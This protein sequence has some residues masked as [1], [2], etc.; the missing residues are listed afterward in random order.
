MILLSSGQKSREEIVESLEMN[1]NLLKQPVKEL[2]EAGLVFQNGNNYRTSNNGQLLIS[3]LMPLLTIVNTFSSEINYWVSRDLQAVPHHLAK[4]MGEL[5]N[6]R[7]LTLSLD[8][9]FEPLKNFLENTVIKRRLH[10][11]I[12]LYDP[13]APKIFKELA[14]KNIEISLIFEKHTYE[15][16]NQSFGEELKSLD[17]SENV[18]LYK[19]DEEINPPEIIISDEEISI[20]F[21]N[22]NGKYDYR[23]LLSSHEDALSWGNE[24]FNYYKEI[25]K[26]LEK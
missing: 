16:M 24:L 20:I 5:E 8:S 26:P 6:S 3:A 25:S 9:M 21:F 23:E 13:E 17:D 15:K 10:I 14:Q 19:I 1:W 22:L 12:S 2:K 18:T 7:I 11:V 4:R